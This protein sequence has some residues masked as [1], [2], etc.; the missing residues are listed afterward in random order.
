MCAAL[1]L[2]KYFSAIH[3][4]LYAPRDLLV[5][6]NHSPL[7]PCL[8]S[9]KSSKSFLVWFYFMQLKEHRF[10]ETIEFI[11]IFAATIL[12]QNHIETTLAVLLHYFFVI[13]GSQLIGNELNSSRYNLNTFSR[14]VI[15]EA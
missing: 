1:R 4:A 9:K 14:H 13:N 6:F 7:N 2:F 15:N 3:I 12:T 10:P 5:L 11:Q 8:H